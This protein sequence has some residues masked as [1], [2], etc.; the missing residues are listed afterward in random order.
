[1]F[2]AHRTRRLRWAA[3]LVIATLA[4]PVG[5]L[6]GPGVRAVQASQ[7]SAQ[8][9]PSSPQPG[10]TPGPAPQPP[11]P[12][13]PEFVPGQLVVTFRVGVSE[14]RVREIARGQDAEIIGAIPRLRTYVLR[15]PA[16]ISPLQAAERFR[17][18]PEVQAADPNYILRAAYHGAPSN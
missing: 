15:L 8:V 17:R 1:M 12:P 6:P 3:V 4:A 11:R 16:G 5:P 14:Q 18:I 2:A 7:Q 10:L 9:P 13:E